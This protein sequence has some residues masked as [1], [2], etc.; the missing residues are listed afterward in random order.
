MKI[1]EFTT[2]EDDEAPKI[3]LDWY[4]YTDKKHHSE[5]YPIVRRGIDFEVGR[6]FSLYIHFFGKSLTLSIELYKTGE[7]IPGKRNEEYCERMGKIAKFCRDLEGEC[8]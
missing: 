2:Y 7:I 1:R 4:K 3:G 5:V 8:S 6:V